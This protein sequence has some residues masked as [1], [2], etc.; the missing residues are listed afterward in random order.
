MQSVFTFLGKRILTVTRREME[1]VSEQSARSLQCPTK[2]KVNEFR[3][4]GEKGC[5]AEQD[6][7][8]DTRSRCAKLHSVFCTPL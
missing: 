6:M 4:S 1:Q 2:V 8:N 5:L 7:K 3:D